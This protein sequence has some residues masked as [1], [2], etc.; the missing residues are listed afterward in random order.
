MKAAADATKSLADKEVAQSDRETKAANARL[1]AASRRAEDLEA[2]GFSG[3][4]RKGRKSPCP[5]Q[6]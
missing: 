1:V 3:T 6:V 4:S 2:E 5:Y